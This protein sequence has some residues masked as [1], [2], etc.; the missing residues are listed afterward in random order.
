M[1]KMKRRPTRGRKTIVT[2]SRLPLSYQ[3][4][5][6]INVR[7]NKS[8]VVPPYMVDSHP[9]M[10]PMINGLTLICAQIGV[11]LYHKLYKHA[12]AGTCAPP[13]A[14]SS[15]SPGHLFELGHALNAKAFKDYFEGFTFGA[16]TQKAH[17][18]GVLHLEFAHACLTPL[19]QIVRVKACHAVFLSFHRYPNTFFLDLG[20]VRQE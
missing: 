10:D 5:K 7:K 15:S 20:F 12:I 8:G 13:R 16:G 9:A 4:C 19:L 14:R 11:E 18:D 17:L 1:I 2:S 6:S 3:Q